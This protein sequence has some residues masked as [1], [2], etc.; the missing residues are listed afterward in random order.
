M[1]QNSFPLRSCPREYISHYHL[2]KIWNYLE[3]IPWMKRRKDGKTEFGFFETIKWLILE[4]V[5]TLLRGGPFHFTDIQCMYKSMS[6]RQV[7]EEHEE[8]QSSP[9]GSQQVRPGPSTSRLLTQVCSLGFVHLFTHTANQIL[10]FKWVSIG[11]QGYKKRSCFLKITF[12]LVIKASKQTN[13]YN[14]SV[15]LKVYMN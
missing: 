10:F 6:R 1:L 11:Y 3:A 13:G 2:L 12:H 5:S 7:G 15:M 4:L 8:T 14:V 9:E